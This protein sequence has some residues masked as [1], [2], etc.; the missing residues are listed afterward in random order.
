MD[1]S[2]I[3]KYCELGIRYKNSFCM[4][5]MSVVLLTIQKLLQPLP[6][7]KSFSFFG[8]SQFKEWCQV[9]VQGCFLQ[10]SQLLWH[11]WHEDHL[12]KLR[13]LASSTANCSSSYTAGSKQ[14]S[15]QRYESP[16]FSKIASP[17]LVGFNPIRPTQRKPKPL[18]S[19]GFQRRKIEVRPLS[20]RPIF[21]FFV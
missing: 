11:S 19:V 12:G 7:G 15:G 4:S 17:R 10:R 6:N 9:N 1:F 3:F 16:F 20:D 13:Y 21:F 18:I 8:T 14:C 2:N 5:L